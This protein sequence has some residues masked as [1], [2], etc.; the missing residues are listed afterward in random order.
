M[1][2]ALLFVQTMQNAVIVSMT[3][4]PLKQNV[5]YNT[6]Q[7]FNVNFIMVPSCQSELIVCSHRK[8]R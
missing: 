2:L 4:Y 8:P 1:L 3:R 7:V 6:F 5:Q